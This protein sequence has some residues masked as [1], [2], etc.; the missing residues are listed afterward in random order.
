MGTFELKRIKIK[1]A[2][3]LKSS[4]YEAHNLN[5]LVGMTKQQVYR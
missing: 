2:L 5:P 3:K 4:E 1:F